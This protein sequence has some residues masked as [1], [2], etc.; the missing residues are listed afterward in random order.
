[1]PDGLNQF[2]DSYKYTDIANEV[3]GRDAVKSPTELLA[4]LDYR[5]NVYPISKIQPW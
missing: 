1:M 2:T 3:L 4:T 5:K